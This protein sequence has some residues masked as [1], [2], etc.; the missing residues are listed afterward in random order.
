MTL[1][2]SLI[3]PEHRICI[4]FFGNTRADAYSEARTG[5]ANDLQVKGAST[6]QGGKGANPSSYWIPALVNGPLN[7]CNNQRKII[8]PD[9]IRVYYKTRH[10]AASKIIPV[11][12]EVIGG[13][14]PH[15]PN[16]GMVHGM[17]ITNA[18]VVRIEMLLH[19]VSMIHQ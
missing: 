14:L 9:R 8:L 3:S 10:P 16:G 4:C 7:G 15:T 17:T 18:M 12:L 5:N 2:Y 13:N 1:L 19:E 11:G 6:A